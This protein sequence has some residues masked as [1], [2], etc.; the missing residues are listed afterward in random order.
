MKKLTVFLL[1][2]VLIIMGLSFSGCAKKKLK[3]YSYYYY[4]KHKKQ[5]QKVVN[6]CNKNYP[7]W[8][9]QEPD[10]FS[11]D[12]RLNNCSAANM[13]ITPPTPPIKPITPKNLNFN[14]NF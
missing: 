10:S 5:A 11:S 12:A 9:N 7:G 1:L 13:A 4:V 6:F 8:Q 3:D 2:G 14:L